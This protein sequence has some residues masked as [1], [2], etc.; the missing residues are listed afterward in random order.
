MVMPRILQANI[1]N[2]NKGGAYILIH[3]VEKQLYNKSIYFDYLTMDHFDDS[4]VLE[5]SIK[6]S[7]NL[8][9][10][11]IVGHILL[12]SYVK[13]VL[14]K[15]Y[16]ETIHINTDTS[17]KAL[18]YA[19]P[20]KKAG[21]KNIIVHAHATGIDGKCKSI[22]RILHNLCINKLNTITTKR[23]ACS[24]EAAVWVFGNNRDC[25]VI[26]N[27][28]KINDYQ[29][30]ADLR[31]ETRNGL[32]VTD[33]VVLGNVGVLS[34]TK[35]QLFLLDVLS[36]LISRGIKAKLL[37]VGDCSPEWNERIKQKAEKLNIYSQIILF[38][39]SNNVKAMLSAMDIMLIPSKFEGFC[40]SLLEAQAS[41]LLCLI[42]DCI[43]DSAIA[44]DNV[45][46]L[47]IEGSEDLW[48]DRVSSIVKNGIG[49]RSGIIISNDF[50]ISYISDQYASLYASLIKNDRKDSNI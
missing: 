3:E 14:A 43:P 39:R 45:I 22:K 28:I 23:I 16:Y 38:G 27:G 34:D 37:L 33:E 42:S 50:D 26:K 18:L 4:D 13:K 1:D 11:K 7:A 31:F 17:W 6:Y 5:G 36:K 12:P 10:N 29:Y 44:S 30:D 35:N 8:R 21:V 15:H 9:K 47:P 2:V 25:I 20:A 32:G 24:K 49:D 40:L 48:A 46:A 19:I 41:G